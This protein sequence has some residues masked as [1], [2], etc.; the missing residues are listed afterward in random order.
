MASSDFTLETSE[1]AF[2]L[3]ARLGEFSPDILPLNVP[4]WLFAFPDRSRRATSG[5]EKTRSEFL[6]APILIA[7]KEFALGEMGIFF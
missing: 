2:G 1:A 6:A 5:S 7:A 4:Q 3:T